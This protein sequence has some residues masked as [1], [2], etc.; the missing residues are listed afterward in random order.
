TFLQN[1]DQV[2][3]RALGD[4]ISATVSPDLLK[5]GSGLLLTSPFTPMLWMGEEWA[6]STPWQFFTSH[7]EPDLAASVRSGRKEEF[8]GHGWT[9]DEVPDP[10]DPQTFRRS[11]LDWSEVE[12]DGHAEMLEWYRRLLALRRQRPGLSDPR[13]HA[14]EVAYDEQA[15]WLVVTRGTLRVAVN[16]AAS[17]QAVPLDGMPVGVLL[18]S[19]PGFVYRTGGIELEPASIAIVEL[20]AGPSGTA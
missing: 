17:R 2:G 20:A 3:N 4:R 16:L 8:A 9:T 19:V 18:S 11:K 13:L 6:A 1:H 7:P 12:H 10:Q 5:V 15:R 14:V